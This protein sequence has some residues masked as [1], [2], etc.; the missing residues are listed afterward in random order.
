MYY[1]VRCYRNVEADDALSRSFAFGHCVCVG[2]HPAEAERSPA[3]PEAL[4]VAVEEIM[5]SME[6]H[7]PVVA[8]AGTCTLCNTE[9]P[10][11]DVAVSTPRRC[12]C[13]RCLNRIAGRSRSVPF[14][15]RTWVSQILDEIEA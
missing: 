7:I 9:V 15:L 2:C 4:T 3:V 8:R 14:A 13:L 5:D 11:D 6:E 12:L 10:A 1:C